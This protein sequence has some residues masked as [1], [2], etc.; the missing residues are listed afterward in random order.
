MSARPGRRPGRSWRRGCGSRGWPGTYVPRQTHECDAAVLVRRHLPGFL[1]RIEEAPHLRPL[2]TRPY[3]TARVLYRICDSM[4]CIAW[5]GNLYEVP[6]EHVT[7]FLP[8]RITSEQVLV[9]GR[10]L[11]C[12]ATHERLRRARRGAAG[13]GLAEIR[14]AI[15]QLLA[16]PVR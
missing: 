5:D 16:A 9:Y 11:S 6:Y 14:A 15:E 3:D 7:D 4:G 2:P 1:A 8:V 13:T 10:D 12:I